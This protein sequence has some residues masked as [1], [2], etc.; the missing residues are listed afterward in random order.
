LL[1][2]HQ[3]RKQLRAS[4]LLT[5]LI[6]ADPLSWE[7]TGPEAKPLPQGHN[8]MVCHWQRSQVKLSCYKQL[9]VFFFSR[10]HAK[11]FDDLKYFDINPSL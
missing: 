7:A 1:L 11:N 9:P 5:G 2:F 10:K 4:G 6:A 8:T 3:Q